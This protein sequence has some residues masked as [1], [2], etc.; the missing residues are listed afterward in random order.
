[1]F[2]RILVF[3]KSPVSCAITPTNSDYHKS[4][5]SLPKRMWY[6]LAK[7]SFSFFISVGKNGQSVNQWINNKLLSLQVEELIMFLL[8]LVVFLLAYGVSSQGLLYRVR[9]PNWVIVRDII[10]FP[11]WILYG[12]LFLDEIQSKSFI[13]LLIER[14]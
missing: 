9:N 6:W 10:Y 11:Y 2:Y 12:E 4:R 14:N 13:L 8:V 3:F 1:M 5:V 7:F